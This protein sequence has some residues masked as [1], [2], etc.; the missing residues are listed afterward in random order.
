MDVVLALVIPAQ[1]PRLAYSNRTIL[2]TA[3]T[4]EIWGRHLR[5]PGVNPED[6]FIRLT[7]SSEPG[8]IGADC[9]GKDAH[10][11]VP[12]YLGHGVRGS[13]RSVLGFGIGEAAY[14]GLDDVHEYVI[15]VDQLGLDYKHTVDTWGE[16][17]NYQSSNAL[18]IQQGD[19]VTWEHIHFDHPIVSVNGLGIT[20][21]ERCEQNHKFPA[22][23]RS[24][25][26]WGGGSENSWTFG[27]MGTFYFSRAE[28]CQG[29]NGHIGKI[30]VRPP[31]RVVEYNSTRVMVNVSN[32]HSVLHDTPILLRPG[33][34]E[35][36]MPTPLR[37]AFSG[38]GPL[39]AQILVA[40]R[41]SGVPMQ[42]GYVV[43]PLL[44]HNSS[45]ALAA[46][47][48]LLLVRGDNMPGLCPG[49]PQQLRISGKTLW[50]DYHVASCTATS[51]VLRLVMGRA[52]GA[53]GSGLYLTRYSY[54]G[55][56]NVQ[57]AR[58]VAPFEPGIKSAPHTYPTAGI[59]SQFLGQVQSETLSAYIPNTASYVQLHGSNLQ[60]SDGNLTA[61]D[62]SVL[63]FTERGSAP[64]GLVQSNMDLQPDRIKVS[65]I[66]FAASLPGRLY[67]QLTIA[68][69]KSV[70]QQCMPGDNLCW[71]GMGSQSDA[72]R[73]DPRRPV[74]VGF[75]T[76]PVSIFQAQTSISNIAQRILVTGHNLPT[77]SEQ[78]C[79]PASVRTYKYPVDD[80]GW[81]RSGVLS[82]SSTHSNCTADAAKIGASGAWCA[83]ESSS[84][85]EW[86]QYELA[87]MGIAGGIGTLVA[88]ETQGRAIG[89]DWM[90]PTYTNGNEDHTAQWVT[91]YMVNT[92]LDGVHWASQPKLFAANLDRDS[93][94]QNRLPAVIAARYVRVI[95]TKWHEWISMRVGLIL[96]EPSIR[97]STQRAVGV[98]FDLVNCT[99]SGVTL[100]LRDGHTWGSSGEELRVREY[101]SSGPINSQV[102]VLLEAPAPTIAQNTSWLAN[103]ETQIFISGLHLKQN[104][105]TTADAVVNF[106]IESEGATSGSSL[107]QVHR[108]TGSILADAYSETGMSV[109][110]KRLH[111]PC[112]LY[113]SPSPRDS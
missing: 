16:G 79:L 22:R 68:G 82:V 38:P 86:I 4:I 104:S 98:D 95:P 32:D 57:I 58:V 40:G 27:A 51:F 15:S 20:Q 101:G 89:D 14:V 34:G 109:S 80:Q 64:L 62:V 50:V 108:P 31:S 1:G 8:C 12:I 76:S 83:K 81:G 71:D 29:S 13:R 88:V 84:G 75:V 112:L 59:S 70:V 103:T 102:G 85:R 43:S 7:N 6:V 23:T 110:F 61:T 17:H 39:F 77:L 72:L 63:F 73:E 36:N 74:L 54:S 18:V 46:N 5:P 69:K 99:R 56:V 90:I 96:S 111:T 93:V 35:D 3:T 52:W 66:G 42:I 113:T 92:S 48:E 45:A 67:A 37:L 97:L 91:E 55:E 2:N 11:P 33:S 53:A 78:S 9:R 47:A 21:A 28:Y 60:G 65:L 105:T 30:V 25:P 41:S 106:W 87:E 10:S 100:A 49:D 94:V 26:S 24:D 19:T 44:V 107:Y